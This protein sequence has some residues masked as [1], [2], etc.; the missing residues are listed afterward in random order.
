M[1]ETALKAI[2]NYEEYTAG[3]YDV[4]ELNEEQVKLA[5][6]VRPE[7]EVKSQSPP[8]STSTITATDTQVNQ[9]NEE[10]LKKY[11]LSSLSG[12]I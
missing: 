5:V 1:G 7:S 4:V 6:A 2:Y 3:F 8:A 9:S 10:I 12:V 11:G